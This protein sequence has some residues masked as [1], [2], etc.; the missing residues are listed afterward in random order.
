MT[1]IKRAHLICESVDFL[2]ICVYAC[3]CIII[4][5]VKGY[6]SQDVELRDSLKAIREKRG[7]LFFFIGVCV[8]S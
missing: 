4:C 1:A 2:L 3:C 5:P 8:T 6:H 7:C